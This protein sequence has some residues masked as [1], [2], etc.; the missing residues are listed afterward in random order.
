MQ[1][2]VARLCLDCNEVHDAQSCPLCG[3]EAFAFLSRWVPAPERRLRARPTTSPEAEAYREL[4]T[5]AQDTPRN[6]LLKGSALGLT[7]VALAGWAW[8][9]NKDRMDSAAEKQTPE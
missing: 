8:R 6:R 4:I 3:S 9:W 5:P 2:H 1:L 7:M